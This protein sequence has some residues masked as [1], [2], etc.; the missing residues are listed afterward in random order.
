MNNSNFKP[1]Q[2]NIDS[3]KM[4][5]DLMKNIKSISPISQTFRT[6][7]INEELENLAKLSQLEKK[8]KD[9]QHELR[10]I[11]MLELMEAMNDNVLSIKNNSD[12]LVFNTEELIET[13]I[14]SNKVSE[15]NLLLIEQTLEKILENE[16]S[17]IF[18]E[19]KKVAV[20]MATQK[21]LATGYIFLLKL[22]PYL[23]NIIKPEFPK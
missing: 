21:G 6:T 18:D 22:L 2:G 10:E 12:N 14:L 17:S 23:Q 13:I 15:A 20:G 3:I 4:N 5:S 8:A 9:E 1:L 7:G 16:S 11:R 19:I